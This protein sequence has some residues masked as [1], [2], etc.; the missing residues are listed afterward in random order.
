MGEELALVLSIIGD[1][2]LTLQQQGI[3]VTA[4]AW[5]EALDLDLL[6]RLVQE[7]KPEEAG[8]VLRARL[9]AHQGEK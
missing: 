3:E 6:I 1:V 5:Q 2:R 7:G 8:D 4:D 9:G